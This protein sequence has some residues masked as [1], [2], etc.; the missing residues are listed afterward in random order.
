MLGLDP[1]ALMPTSVLTELRMV[2]DAR[3]VKPPPEAPPTARACAWSRSVLERPSASVDIGVVPQSTADY[4]GQRG[5][6]QSDVSGFPA[7]QEPNNWMGANISCVVRIDVAPGQALFVSF[8]NT[9]GDEPGAT[10]ELMCERA[11]RAAEGVMQQL[12]ATSK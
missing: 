6:M 12:L 7:V 1:C 4:L 2:P 8:Y 3:V 9:L 5:A 10:H 11:H